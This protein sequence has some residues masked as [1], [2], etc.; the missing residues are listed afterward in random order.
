MANQH[1]QNAKS[2]ERSVQ[3]L[4]QFHST[5][6]ALAIG[7][8][9]EKFLSSLKG[10]EDAA[11][12]FIVVAMSVAFLSTI[13]PFYH[14]MSRHLYEAH[15]TKSVMGSGGHAVPLLLDI[16]TFIIEAGLLVAM[17]RALDTPQMFL[18]YWSGLLFVDILWS[19]V[20]WRIQ[21]SEKPLWAANNF[22]CL[23]V[24]WLVWLCLPLLLSTMQ[25][26]DD[27]QIRITM[28][29]AIALIEVSRS[30]MDYKKNW[31]FYFPWST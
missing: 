10:G 6:V 11:I 14:G 19:L 21:K 12:P 26:L 18:F 3:T 30:V 5:I 25:L 22:A 7:S 16:F 23:L 9:A 29:M 17:S 2:V 31:K 8:G 15:V 28:V 4:Q 24:A 27:R 1:E 20:V 13:V